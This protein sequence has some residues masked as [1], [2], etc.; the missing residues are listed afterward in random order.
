MNIDKRRGGLSRRLLLGLAAVATWGD[1]RR[2][3]SAG[4]EP[5]GAVAEIDGEASAERN[6]EGR[7]LAVGSSLFLGDTLATAAQSKLGALL[8]RK[9]TLRLGARTKVTIDRFIINRGGV[10]TLASG[11]ILLDTGAGKFPS[12]LSVE[13]PFALIAVR[14]T[15]FFAGDLN[16]AFS[17]FVAHGSLAVT[18][19]GQSVRLKAGEGTD[20]SRPGDAPE[21]AKKWGQPKIAKAMA[22]VR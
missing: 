5:V 19:G 3:V 14:G 17:V 6:K 22:L 9:T 20:I 16:G 13:S 18:A 4:E 21:P 12:G 11:A 15:R 1:L 8:A 10:L 2:N 7:K